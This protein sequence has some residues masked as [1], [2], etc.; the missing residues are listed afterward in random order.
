VLNSIESVKHN[1]PGAE[2]DDQ[3]RSNWPLRKRIDEWRL[4]GDQ[5]F[6]R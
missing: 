2:V 3:K 4:A 6:G 1:A 5:R